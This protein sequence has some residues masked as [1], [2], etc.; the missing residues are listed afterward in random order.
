MRQEYGLSEPSPIAIA[1]QDHHE[2]EG[3]P[4]AEAVLRVGEELS[5]GLQRIAAAIEGLGKQA[6]YGK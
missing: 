3:I 6:S 1:W 5:D 2:V 4:L